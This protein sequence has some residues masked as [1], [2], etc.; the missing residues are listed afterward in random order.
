MS[1]LAVLSR[2][3][4]ALWVA[5]L[6]AALEIVAL[7]N[8]RAPLF[9]Q[10]TTQI[11]VEN[12]VLI[13]LNPVVAGLSCAIALALFEPARWDLVRSSP[14]GGFRGVL[15]QTWQ[16]AVWPIIVHLGATATLVGIGLKRGIPGYP[17]LIPSLLAI[18]SIVLFA[19]IGVG[20]ARRWQSRIA[21]LVVTVGA[22]LLTFFVSV[23]LPVTFVKFGG[24]T[25]ELLG[26]RYRSDVL[27]LQV[28]WVVAGAAVS[29]CW[30]LAPLVAGRRLDPGLALSAIAVVVIAVLLASRGDSRFEDAPISWVCG[31]SAPRVC[32]AQEHAS[33]LPSE[34]SRIR[35]AVT[36]AETLGLDNI[37][38]TFRQAAGTFGP[39]VAGDG[40]FTLQNQF[41]SEQAI[42]DVLQST[43][44]CS[45]AWSEADLRQLDIVLR[46][47]VHRDGVAPM[48]SGPSPSLDHAKMAVAGLQNSCQRLS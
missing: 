40:F 21:P 16:A 2:R 45:A 32:V 8:A 44:P 29:I 7:R 25:V 3:S 33:S 41:T 23:T 31:G 43:I 18:G 1:L 13:L 5:P 48:S 20:V 38:D 47:A 30:T 15:G 19:A 46:W 39:P 4:P 12:G 22:Y 9:T 34:E 10:W 37:P 17:L 36:T 42:L 27:A 28:A 14:D 11:D 24:A 26:L 6:L 35:D